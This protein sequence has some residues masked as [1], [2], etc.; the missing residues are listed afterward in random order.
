VVEE[1]ALT[2]QFF[3]LFFII[4]ETVFNYYFY[5]FKNKTINFLNIVVNFNYCFKLGIGVKTSF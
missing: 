2:K 4:N 3:I 1:L 5:Y